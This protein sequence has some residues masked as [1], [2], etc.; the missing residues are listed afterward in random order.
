[1]QDRYVRWK[2]KPGTLVATWD[3]VL[4]WEPRPGNLKI[5]VRTEN[6]NFRSNSR[7][8]TLDSVT[9][10]RP[11][12]WGPRLLK[13]GWEARPKALNNT[14]VPR[15]VIWWGPKPETLDTQ[16]IKTL[17]IFTQS[18]IPRLAPMKFRI[19]QVFWPHEIYSYKSSISLCKTVHHFT[20]D[21][22]LPFKQYLMSEKLL[23]LEKKGNTLFWAKAIS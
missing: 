11:N 2:L 12:S 10:V 13:F 8:E 5:W 14:W 20:K 15:S 21:F 17:E 7:S 9:G 3:S 19:Y 1:M 6:W 4:V 16:K 22:A 23:V 18:L